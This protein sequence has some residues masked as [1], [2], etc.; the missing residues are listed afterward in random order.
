MA[1]KVPTNKNDPK[2]IIKFSSKKRPVKYK[3]NETS[4]L[5]FIKY[6]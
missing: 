4:P 3:Y 1:S 5:K 6:K 2:D